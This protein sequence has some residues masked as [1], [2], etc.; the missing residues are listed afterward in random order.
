MKDRYDSDHLEKFKKT[1]KTQYKSLEDIDVINMS[2]EDSIYEESQYEEKSVKDLLKE[3]KELD[4]LSMELDE[5]S[6]KSEE[7]K[8]LINDHSMMDAQVGNLEKTEPQ[9]KQK[10]ALAE[11][12]I[13]SNETVSHWLRKLSTFLH[14]DADL[15][16]D[17]KKDS[18][19][20]VRLID[21]IIKLRALLN[22]KDASFDEIMNSVLY[23]SESASAYYDSHRGYRWTDTG[24]YRKDIAKS[25]T[26][27]L[28]RFFSRIIPAFGKTESEE[29]LLIGASFTKDEKKRVEKRIKNLEKAYTNWGIGFSKDEIIDE[30]QRV[31]DTFALLK[32]YERDIAIYR[33]QH[34]DE[35]MPYVIRQYDLLKKQCLIIDSLEK[36]EGNKHTNPILQEIRDYAAEQTEDGKEKELSFADKDEGLNEETIKAIEEVDKWFVRNA[37]NGGIMGAIAGR[38]KNDNSDIIRELLGKS[39]RERLYIYYLLE[40]GQRKNPSFLSVCDSQSY[41]PDLNGIKGVM[42]ATKLKF[43]SRFTGSYVYMHKLTEAMNANR[44]NKGLIKTL[45]ELETETREDVREQRLLVSIKEEG[46][47][48]KLTPKQKLERAAVERK[49]ALRHTY[50]AMKKVE[51]K[52]RELEKAKTKEEKQEIKEE[53][54]SLSNAS[55]RALKDLIEKDKQVGKAQAAFNLK[56]NDDS[57]KVQKEKGSLDAEGVDAGQTTAQILGTLAGNVSQVGWGLDESGLADLKIIADADVAVSF[58]VASSTLAFI[59]SI[60]ALGTQASSMH[61]GDIFKTAFSA[62]KSLTD[63]AVKLWTGTEKITNTVVHGSG[64]AFKASEALQITGTVAAGATIAIGAYTAFSGALDQG[65]A[66]RAKQYLKKKHSN[67]LR[68]KEDILKDTKLSKKEKE[69]ELKKSKEVKYEKNMLKLSER[70]SDRKMTSGKLTMASGAMALLGVLVPGVG[71]IVSVAGLALVIAHKVADRCVMNSIREQTFDEFF[72]FENFFTTIKEKMAAAKKTIYSEE[73]FKDSL[74]RKLAAAAGYADLISAQI[75]IAT[76]YAELVY[77]KLFSK[78]KT[79]DPNE[80]KAYIQM[81]KS[82][83]LPYNEKK[84]KPDKKLLIRKM[85]GK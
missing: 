62:G 14:S 52:Y 46:E 53:I 39:K 42:L 38:F 33:F 7:K 58:A 12:E 20:Y 30:R 41:K 35:E 81:V 40:T 24:Q 51:V 67:N 4:G 15:S 64:A 78:D 16:M 77:E 80:K 61:I 44:Q 63:A 71:T 50:T 47:E 73:N 74:R 79:T 34:K 32:T 23:L 6:E 59:S 48:L 3:E 9:D 57:L 11:K 69:A 66:I 56:E 21:T 29:D 27:F 13:L 72:D 54:E 37:Y 28:E 43:Y 85:C 2:D 75:G 60:Y 65:N 82:L 19:Q 68:S 22:A 55:K 8:I 10:K 1:N 31:R 26:K 25:V 5:I 18:P 45:S 36:K 84:Q 70:L 76:K 83:G 49:L 17:K